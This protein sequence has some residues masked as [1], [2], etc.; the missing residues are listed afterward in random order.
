MKAG[1]RICGFEALMRRPTHNY[2]TIDKGG[3][4]VYC[5]CMPSIRRGNGY[6]WMKVHHRSK[7]HHLEQWYNQ[8]KFERNLNRALRRKPN[9]I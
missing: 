9:E 7:A 8:Y 2:H 3:R 4:A 1:D 6:M 5:G